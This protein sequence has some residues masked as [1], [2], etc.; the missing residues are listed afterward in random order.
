[1]LQGCRREAVSFVD[2]KLTEE[3]FPQPPRVG[4]T[5][6]V[7][8]LTGLSGEPITD[9][10]ITLEVNMTHAGMTP[11]IADAR[12]FEPGRYRTIVQLSMAGDW[13]VVAH[14]SLVNGRKLDR[15]FEINGVAL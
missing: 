11:I 15:Q 9:A 2:L 3:V 14:A 13:V 7:L 1:L 8:T 6:I 5:T 10:R 12:E 4:F